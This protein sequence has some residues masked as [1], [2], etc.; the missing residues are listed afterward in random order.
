MSLLRLGAS[1]ALLALAGCTRQATPGLPPGTTVDDLPESESW[2]A[3]LRA[4][5]DGQPRLEIDAPYLARYDRAD[6][7]YV[8]LGPAPGDSASRVAVRLYDDG[9]LSATVS[10]GEAWYYED[11]GRLVTRGDVRTSVTGEQGAQIEAEA[12][13]VRGDTV[14]ASGRVRADVQSGPGARIEAGRLLLTRGGSFSASGGVTARLDGQAQATVRAPRVSGSTG[15]VEASGGARVETS[16]GRWLESSRVV[17]NERS[18]RFRA[19]GAFTFDGP[20]ERVRG[21][22]LNASADLSR[23]SFRNATGEIEVRE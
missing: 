12:M 9:Q 11:D 3:R 1:C 13:E 5:D 10:A 8:Y 14:E 23:Y 19:P 6:T 4:T 2:N 17:W 15:S 21:V 16:G 22:G 7:A 18:E 20:G